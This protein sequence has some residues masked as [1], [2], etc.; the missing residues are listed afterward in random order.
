MLAEARLVPVPEPGKALG[1]SI[2]VG[3]ARV[4]LGRS[5]VNSAV[6]DDP[7][8]SK[9]H[10]EIVATRD[11]YVLKD[12]GSSNGTWVNGRMIQSH[13]LTPGDVIEFGGEKFEFEPGGASRR[14]STVSIVSSGPVSS[15]QIV[16]ASHMGDL[17][18]VD[19]IH[20]DKVLRKAYQRVRAAFEAV[21]DLIDIT[22]I[23]R[24]SER[25]LDV[26][27]EL[28]PAET[29]AVMLFDDGGELIP[30]ASRSIGGVANPTGDTI[31]ISKAIVDQVLQSKS[32]VL[33]SDALADSRWNSSESIIASGMRSLMCVPLA[34][35]KKIFGLLHAGNASRVAA[36][37]KADLELL[38]GVGAGGGVA[39]S[40]AFL[41]LRLAQE[42]RNRESLGRFP[43]ARVGGAGG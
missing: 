26:V 17:G 43:V 31:N 18:A 7:E 6:L 41:A 27:F 36:F 42:A 14:R 37:S 40:N 23:R 12:L 2:V 34:N 33:A 30:W 5:H 35:A 8:V 21:Q 15:T 28:V 16:A 20:D 32:A 10:A 19:E 11:G 25:I 4:S 13:R 9:F 24:L 38:T 3:Q 39:L 22:D 1:E 29:G